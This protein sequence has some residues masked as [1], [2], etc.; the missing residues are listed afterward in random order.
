MVNQ[1]RFAPRGA[2]DPLPLLEFGVEAKFDMGWDYA[3]V[4]VPN[5][6]E[7]PERTGLGE[8]SS[9]ALEVG[10]AS[11]E[12]FARA[13]EFSEQLAAQTLRLLGYLWG[14]PNRDKGAMACETRSLVDFS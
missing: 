13:D 14:R 12:A 5:G 4:V 1:R 9:S 6:L 11:T 2:L 7:M 8:I 3:L 10:I